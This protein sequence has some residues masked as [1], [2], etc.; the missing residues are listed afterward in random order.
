MK[1]ELSE[2]IMRRKLQKNL[3]TISIVDSISVKGTLA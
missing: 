2:L 3:A 1:S